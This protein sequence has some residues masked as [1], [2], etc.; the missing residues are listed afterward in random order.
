VPRSASLAVLD[1]D[2]ILGTWDFFRTIE[3]AHGGV[4]YAATGRATLAR[5]GDVI[6]WHEDGLLERDG[7]RYPVT[8]TLRIVSAAGTAVPRWS[9]EFDDGRPFHEWAVGTPLVHLCGADAYR[10]FITVDAADAGGPRE[11]RVNWNVTGPAKS[12]SLATHYR[13][14]VGLDS[15]IR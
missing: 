7:G 8:R 11:W 15:A 5:T 10:G 14:T 9:V 4:D 3:D 6:R 2:A 12:Y 13:R 1:P